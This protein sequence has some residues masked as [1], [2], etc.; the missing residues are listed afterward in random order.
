MA[1]AG[2]VPRGTETGRQLF[3]ASL[4]KI[5]RPVE[6]NARCPS[7]AKATAKTEP[8]TT[9]GA[10]M[11]QSRPPLRERSRPLSAPRSRRLASVG[12]MASAMAPLTNTPR[13]ADTHVAP[14]SRERNSPPHALGSW[15]RAGLADRSSNSVSGRT[16]WLSRVASAEPKVGN[17]GRRRPVT[18]V[19]SCQDAR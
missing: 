5:P 12:L 13:L 2:A 10:S 15:L 16:K 18:V 11:V 19:A 4:P 14:S 9:E 17:P 6:A 8:S 1:R 7:G 3:S